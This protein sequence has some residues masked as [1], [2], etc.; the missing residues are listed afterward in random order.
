[1]YVYKTSSGVLSRCGWIAVAHWI[2]KYSVF[3]CN[4][5]SFFVTLLAKYSCLKCLFASV[6]VCFRVNSRWFSCINIYRV[7]TICGAKRHRL[8]L[9]FSSSV[10]SCLVSRWCVF[11]LCEVLRLTLALVFINSPFIHIFTLSSFEIVL[12][13]FT[14]T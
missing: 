8:F 6:A 13:L 2:K 11:E 1:M 7:E 9:Y 4:S 14:L 5:I 12:L 3:L 10:S